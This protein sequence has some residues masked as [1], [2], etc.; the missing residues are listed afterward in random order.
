MMKKYF[1]IIAIALFA[2]VSCAPEPELSVDQTSVQFD[3]AGGSTTVMLKCNVQ[4]T[5]TSSN[6]A[7]TVSPASGVEDCFVTISVPATKEEN[8]VSGTV[9]FSAVNKAGSASK[10]VS[11]SQSGAPGEIRI[12]KVEVD[13]KPAGLSL[14]GEGCEMKIYITSNFGWSFAVDQADVKADK[15]SG[16]AGD[17]VITVTVP[18]SPVFEGRH[19]TFHVD[20]KGNGETFGIDQEGGIVVYG[21][22]TYHAVKMQDGKWWMKENLRY[23]PEG[24]NPS[25][26]LLTPLAGI[27][28]P[29]VVNG[30]HTAADFSTDEAAIKSN[31]YLYSTEVAFGLKPGDLTS[32]AEAEKYNGA[33]GIC[34]EGWHIP[35]V[36]DMMGLT[37]KCNSKTDNTAAPYYDE[38]LKGGSIAKLNADGFNAGAWG[39]VSI[40]STAVA[41]GTM[42]GWLKA[43]PD[44]ISSGFMV[45]STHYKTTLN[46]DGSVK[47]IQFFGFMPMAS[48]GTFNGAYNNYRTGA[49][50][51]CVKDAK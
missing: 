24:M 31:G 36:D 40:A 26:S 37:G 2:L 38:A 49:S 6:S 12:T 16:S 45:G 50:L 13:G 7:I 46:E 28:Y 11:V 48:N 25:A 5:A 19:I 47:N 42:T 21:G 27:W 32:Q 22:E 43:N 23:V 39:A 3:S 15:S 34:P 4:W 35:T 9:T 8:G 41:K 44:I 18:A 30:D 14:P 29:V 10:T 17:N 1:A 20:C 33:R 51:R